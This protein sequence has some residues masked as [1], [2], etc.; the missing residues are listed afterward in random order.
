MANRERHY[1]AGGLNTQVL[2]RSERA[3]PAGEAAAGDQEC[4][5]EAPIEAGGIITHHHAVGHHHRPCTIVGARGAA[6][7]AAKRELDPEGMLNPGVLIDP[8]G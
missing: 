3:R 8:Q 7:R 4:T 2:Q 5:S 6:L 1:A